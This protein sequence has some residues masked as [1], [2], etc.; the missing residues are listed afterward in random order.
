MDSMLAEIERLKVEA[1]KSRMEAE[2]R[3]KN[4]TKESNEKVNLKWKLKRQ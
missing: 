2:E 4:I 3:M 1:E